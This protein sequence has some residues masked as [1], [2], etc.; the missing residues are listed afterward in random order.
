MQHYSWNV[1]VKI[2]LSYASMVTLASWYLLNSWD[3]C[4]REEALVQ[5]IE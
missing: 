3:S 2:Q 5:V 4:L 1:S